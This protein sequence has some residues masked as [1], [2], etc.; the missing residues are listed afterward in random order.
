[1]T[2]PN[3]AKCRLCEDIIESYHQYDYV[4]CSCGE[5]AVDGGPEGLLCRAR[6][7]E[8]FIRIDEEGNE[9]GITLRNE[10]SSTEQPETQTEPPRA[11]ALGQPRK[12]NASILLNEMIKNYES[13]P[14]QAMHAPATN[15]DLLSM[16]YLVGALFKSSGSIE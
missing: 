14:H 3:K 12:E 16:L 10:E 7:W 6:N 11:Q 2:K 5:I 8:N 9:R 4:K 1:M 13:L 15:A